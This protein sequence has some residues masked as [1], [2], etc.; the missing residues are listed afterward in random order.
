MAWGA[1]ARAA[2][3]LARSTRRGP[4]RSALSAAHNLLYLQKGRNRG[5]YSN[6]VKLAAD[7]RHFKRFYKLS[8]LAA[9]TRAV[10]TRLM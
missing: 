3:L 8:T 4:T 6:R 2:A 1:K 10:K 9:Y 7:T 5:Q